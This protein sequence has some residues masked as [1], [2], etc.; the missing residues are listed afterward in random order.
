MIKLPIC[1][2]AYTNTFIGLPIEVV[3]TELNSLTKIDVFLH[4]LDNKAI[5]WHE[6]WRYM[7]VI[8]DFGLISIHPES[9]L[10]RRIVQTVENFFDIMKKLRQNRNDEGKSQVWDILTV[11]IDNLSVLIECFEEIYQCIGKQFRRNNISLSNP[12]ICRV[13]SKYVRNCFPR[14]F[15]HLVFCN[16]IRC[17]INWEFQSITNDSSI[18]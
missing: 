15:P 17:E 18:K 5:N 12:S 6:S 13:S 8:R 7:H 16:K 3:P 14:I 4:N 10:P 2:P 9:H 1:C 11:N